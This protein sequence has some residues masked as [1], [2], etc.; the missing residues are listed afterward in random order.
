MIHPNK[1]TCLTAQTLTCMLGNDLSNVGLPALVLLGEGVLLKQSGL[2]G[3]AP[4]STCLIQDSCY[5]YSCGVMLLSDVSHSRWVTPQLML[6]DGSQQG[7][8]VGE[9]TW[10]H[11]K[12]EYKCSQSYHNFCQNPPA[13][14]GTGLKC[15]SGINELSVQAERGTSGT[16]AWYFDLEVSFALCTYKTCTTTQSCG[17]KSLFVTGFHKLVCWVGPPRPVFDP[18]HHF[19]FHG[20]R[21]IGAPWIHYSRFN[22]EDI[23]FVA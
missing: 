16:T 22:F 15:N 18:V 3:E 12:L 19:S 8:G 14:S 23:N 10:R 17:S 9:V 7:A 21:F 5:G 4:S 6:W 2:V 1:S 11:L 13:A 20:T